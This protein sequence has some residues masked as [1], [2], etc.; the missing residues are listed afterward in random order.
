MEG[1]T[2]GGAFIAKHLRARL[3]ECPL[4]Y[5]TP[6]GDEAGS[7]WASFRAELD[8][9]LANDLDSDDAVRGANL[10]FESFRAWLTAQCCTV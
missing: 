7:T 10:T 3:G 4:R 8:G 6:Y 1:S 9:A 2:L 5:L